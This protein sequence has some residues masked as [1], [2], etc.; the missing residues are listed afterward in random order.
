MNGSFLISAK[1]DFMGTTLVLL[2][3]ISCLTQSE[4]N[5][6]F[7]ENLEESYSIN[8]TLQTALIN[9]SDELLFYYVGLECRINNE[10]REV[11]NDINDPESKSSTLLKLQVK[12]NK[13]V[14]FLIN[15]ILGDFIPNFD[16]Y[17]LKINYGNS[18]DAINKQ[19]YS[20]P[21][22]IIK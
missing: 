18:V 2:L 3:F 6:I 10:W 11:V 22:K 20:P 4:M 9:K 13:D 17:R 15:K 19:Y 21:F 14:S 12:E 5:N 7:I 1:T 8:D 16:T